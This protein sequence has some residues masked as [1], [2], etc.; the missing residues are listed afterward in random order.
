MYNT[1][2]YYTVKLFNYYKQLSKTCCDKANIRPIDTTTIELLTQLKSC[3]HVLYFST[4]TNRIIE[5]KSIW[6]VLTKQGIL[7]ELRGTHKHTNQI[8]AL[9]FQTYTTL[10]KQ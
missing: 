8:G 5:S 1:S 2:L 10:C 7:A 4:R 9:T 6:I 3:A